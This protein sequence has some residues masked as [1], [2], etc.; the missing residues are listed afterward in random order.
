[1]SVVVDASAMVEIV[2]SSPTGRA[3]ASRLV[4]E[5]VAAPDVIDVE[6]ASAI[7]RQQRAGRM[8]E[9]EVSRALDLLLDWPADRIP[10]RLLVRGTRRWW[11]NVT[12]YDALYL[13]VAEA[14]QARVLTCD[15]RLARAPAVGVSVE[16]VRVTGTLRP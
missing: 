11:P 10:S 1:V 9:D 14:R 6:V 4:G 13:A 5:A 7:R 12:A 2:Q 16:N 8:D 3:V 15:G